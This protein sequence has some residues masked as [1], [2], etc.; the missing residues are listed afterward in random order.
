MTEP[1][2]IS[3][4][5]TSNND[6]SIYKVYNKSNGLK[7]VTIDGINRSLPNYG[8]ISMSGSLNIIDSDGW[9]KVQSD[10]NILPDVTIDIYLDDILQYTFMAENEFTYTKQ[11]KFVTINL[12]DKIESLQNKK[13]EYGM[14]FDNTNGYV[15]FVNLCS[16]FGL[17]CIMDDDTKE[18]LGNLIIGKTYIKSDTFWNILQEFVYG[19]RCIF[20][21]KGGNY[22]I[23]RMEE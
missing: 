18:F 12:V 11:D 13:T 10:N 2:K 8:I 16:Q 20:Y 7:S 15:M 1:P 22:Y 14:I 23:K 19:C 17:S 6:S 21:R 9:L 3:I 5:I 4:K